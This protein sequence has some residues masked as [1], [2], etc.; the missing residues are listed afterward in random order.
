[1]AECDK[2]Q[3]ATFRINKF[4]EKFA[5]YIVGA[6][7]SVSGWVWNQQNSRVD[8]LEQQVSFL[9]QDKV[10]RIELKDE[11]ALMRNQIELTKSDIIT[12]QESMKGDIL[13]RLDYI[14]RVYPPMSPIQ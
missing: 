11:I 9:T 10:S 7:I 6:V 2:E 14:L 8:K 4:I 13:S 12:R 5:V 3:T 1:M